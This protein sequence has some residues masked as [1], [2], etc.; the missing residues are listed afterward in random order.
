MK[1]L[2]VLLVVFVLSI[3]VLQFFNQKYDTVLA[4]RIAM[5]AMLCFTAI[6]HFAFTKGMT[7]MLPSIIPFKTEIVYFTGIVEVIL[8]IGLLVSN[9]KVYSAWILIFF[10]VILLP[11]NI[12]AAIKQ[13]DLQKATFDGYGLSYLWFRIPLQLLFIAWIYL[14]SIRF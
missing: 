9:W 3:F 8:G 5:C 2:V 7:M 14:S 11:A 12:Y 1:P 6:G 13:V 10:F 4:A